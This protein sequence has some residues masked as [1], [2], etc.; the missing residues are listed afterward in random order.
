MI[1]IVAIITRRKQVVDLIH[2]INNNDSLISS[3]AAGISSR[4]YVDHK[5]TIEPS[6][7]EFILLMGLKV[8]LENID[9]QLFDEY[10]DLRRPNPGNTSKTHKK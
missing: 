7:A 10:V 2:N 9:R 3:A 6:A 5:T 8:E 4:A 1:D